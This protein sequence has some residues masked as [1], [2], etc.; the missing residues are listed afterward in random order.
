MSSLNKNSTLRIYGL[1]VTTQRNT[2][3]DLYLQ[4]ANN[5]LTLTKDIR[6]RLTEAFRQFQGMYNTYLA[7]YGLAPQVTDLRFDF[8]NKMVSITNLN[9]AA[10]RNYVGTPSFYIY[11]AG[12]NSTNGVY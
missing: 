6:F 3:V 4:D 2:Y 12:M 7:T 11:P 5:V 10:Y 1:A 8:G 9:T